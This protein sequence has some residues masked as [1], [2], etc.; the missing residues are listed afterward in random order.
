MESGSFSYVVYLK[1]TP[2][3]L[4]RAL[5]DGTVTPRYWFGRR[6]ES[7]W[8]RG[9]PVRFWVDD[10]HGLDVSGEVLEV[11][12]PHA[13][14][15]SWRVEHDAEMRAAGSSTVAFA[16]WALAIGGPFGQYDWYSPIYGAVLLPLYTL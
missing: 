5:T 8:M 2:E 1:A 7:T 13:L 9:A 16:I 11:D 6:V 10:G 4:W 15:Y 12:R 14:S 3:E